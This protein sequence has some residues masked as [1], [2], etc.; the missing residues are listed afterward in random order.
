MNELNLLKDIK[1][2]IKMYLLNDKKDLVIDNL[3]YNLHMINMSYSVKAY[4]KYYKLSNKYYME[5]KNDVFLNG[6]L[7]YRTWYKRSY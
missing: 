5:R 3:N 1:G 4:F 7:L 2:L 6:R